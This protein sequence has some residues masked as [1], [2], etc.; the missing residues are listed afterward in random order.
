[1]EKIGIYKG[2]PIY[3][4]VTY[5]LKIC[6]MCILRLYLVYAARILNGILEI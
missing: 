4:W 1:M 5:A 6:V 2:A 3:N